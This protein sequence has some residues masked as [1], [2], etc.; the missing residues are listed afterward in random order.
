MGPWGHPCVRPHSS[1]PQLC[2]LG[3]GCSTQSVPSEWATASSSST[4]F[5]KLQ[6]PI[7]SVGDLRTSGSEVQEVVL[8]KSFLKQHEEKAGAFATG[9]PEVQLIQRIPQY[10]WGI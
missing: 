5:K 4:H 1:Y 10:V 6:T 2:Q 3:I 8:A 9:S 7:R